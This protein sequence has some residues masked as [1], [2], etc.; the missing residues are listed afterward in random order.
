MKRIIIVS[1]VIPVVYVS[2]L[3]FLGGFNPGQEW[4]V[5]FF[6]LPFIV[7]LP[8][9]MFGYSLITAYIKKRNNPE[10][11]INSVLWGSKNNRITAIVVFVVVAIAFS[12]YYYFSMRSF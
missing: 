6:F 3:F 10:V 12:L 9:V 5:S 11:Q 4:P 8:F 7:A 1:I 2:F